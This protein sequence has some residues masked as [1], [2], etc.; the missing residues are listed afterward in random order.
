MGRVGVA[1]E[2]EQGWFP[3]MDTDAVDETAD[4]G[5]LPDRLTNADDA[6]LFIRILPKPK[7]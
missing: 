1:P 3:I 2:S 4:E 7:S 6:E 5:M